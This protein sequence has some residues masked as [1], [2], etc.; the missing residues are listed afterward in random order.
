MSVEGQELS[1]E[2]LDER[3]R[4]FHMGQDGLEDPHPLFNRCVKNAP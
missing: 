2:A 3:I 1:A 4:G